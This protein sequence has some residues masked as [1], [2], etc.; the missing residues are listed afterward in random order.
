MWEA[1]NIHSKVCC[2]LLLSRG[3][4]V[5]ICAIDLSKA[6]D[7]MNHCGLFIKLMRRR[8]PV[9]L[10]SLLEYWFSLG[11]T[12]V[13]WDTIMSANFTLSCGIRQGGVLYPYLF[14]VYVDVLVDKV[15]I[16]AHAVLLT[17][18]VAAL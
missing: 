5:N 16:A 15:Q 3:S 7:K 13:K 17:G 2:E 8:I 11:V 14:A 18:Y 1:S 9:Q 4:T 10:L 6:F 12:C